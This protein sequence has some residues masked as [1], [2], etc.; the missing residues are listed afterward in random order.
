MAR[1]LAACDGSAVS[2]KALQSAAE[3]AAA[4]AR[5]LTVL[6][7]A[8]DMPRAHAEKI[9]ADALRLAASHDCQADLMVGAGDAGEAILRAAVD[10]QANLIVMGAHSHSRIRSLLLG[11]TTI[12][13]LA[14]TSVPVMLVR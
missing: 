10:R 8:D 11:C 14:N 12:Q 1:I 9:A 3:L 6:T 2:S 13:V 4:L 7:V 5:P